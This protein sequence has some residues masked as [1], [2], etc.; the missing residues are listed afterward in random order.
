MKRY[1]ILM[2]VIIVALVSF[3]LVQNL[4]IGDIVQDT[5]IKKVIP[6]EL[7]K[8]LS[9]PLEP[10]SIIKSERIRKGW[11][12][13]FFTIS[14]EES[15]EFFIATVF[16]PFEKTEGQMDYFSEAESTSL[17]YLL[18]LT[19]LKEAH[20]EGHEI[21]SFQGCEIVS[22]A[23]LNFLVLRLKDVQINEKPFEEYLK[24]L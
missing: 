11:Y 12:C 23:N 6:Y 3:L 1:F 2:V 4:K 13:Y 5:I 21:V 17:I 10:I 18:R 15:K 24:Y 7:S 8:A 14:W 16:D 20:V 9:T 19:G 22:L